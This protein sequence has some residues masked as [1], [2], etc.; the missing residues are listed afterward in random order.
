MLPAYTVADA[1]ATYDTHIG[2]RNVRFQMNVK[3]LFNRQYYPSSANMYFVSTGDA[4][5][6][7]LLTTIDF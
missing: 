5:Q 3:N 1:F 4:R 2:G 7:S 6:L